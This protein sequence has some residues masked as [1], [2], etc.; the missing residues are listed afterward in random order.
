M[1]AT[2]EAALYMLVSPVRG[3]IVISPFFSNA[4]VTVF[5]VRTQ[6]LA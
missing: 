6:Q 5:A 2:E 4:A 1:S 3:V